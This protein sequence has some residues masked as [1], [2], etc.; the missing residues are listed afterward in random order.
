MTP[1]AHTYRVSRIN[2]AEDH[3]ET[4]GD[5][6]MDAGHSS[7]AMTR[8]YRDRD[9][10]INKDIPWSKGYGIAGATNRGISALT[11]FKRERG[12]AGEKAMLSMP[13]FALDEQVRHRHLHHMC[14]QN[15]EEGTC[16][17][18]EAARCP[19]PCRFAGLARTGSRSLRCHLFVHFDGSC[20]DS[21][22]SGS[23]RA[24]GPNGRTLSAGDLSSRKADVCA[25]SN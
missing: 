8:S 25:R 10:P 4:I 2:N 21:P 20:V 9:R 6:S 18:E 16:Y 24:L 23:V 22:G 17:P 14:I 1:K 3:D 11:W 19:A 5:V 13:Y 12:K 15:E 7:T